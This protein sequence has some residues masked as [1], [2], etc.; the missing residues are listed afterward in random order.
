[1]KLLTEQGPGSEANRWNLGLK[2]P[3]K[4]ALSGQEQLETSLLL[5][6]HKGRF[7][8]AD[9]PMDFFDLAIDL[10]QIELPHLFPGFDL[11]LKLPVHRIELP[12]RDPM[13][14]NEPTLCVDQFLHPHV[15]R[16]EEQSLQARKKGGTLFAHSKQGLASDSRLDGYH[17]SSM[18][19]S[20]RIAR[21][22]VTLFRENY[23]KV[24]WVGAFIFAPPKVAS[25]S[26]AKATL[27]TLIWPISQGQF[28]HLAAVLILADSHRRQER[29]P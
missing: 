27:P 23:I 25:S 2:F 15:K 9:R 5:V 13:L 19:D 1:M 4:P 11:R 6:D 12:G 21:F 28:K 22:L 29:R 3:L 14:G 7:C 24:I 20:A 16:L 8:R 18:Q 17:R 26:A 10:G